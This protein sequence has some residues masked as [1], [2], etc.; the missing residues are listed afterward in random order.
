MSGS[1]IAAWAGVSG[2]ALCWAGA[3]LAQSAPAIEEIVVSA[4]KTEERLQDVPIAV[5]AFSRAT[6]DRKGVQDIS[7]LSGV[8]AGLS[9]ERDFGRR[10]DRPSIRGQ[11]SILGT[12]NAASFLDGVFIPDSL[13][14]TEMAFVERVEVIKGPQSA[15]Y[16]RQTFSGAISYVS[17]LPGEVPEGTFKATFAE[18]GEYDV[19][20]SYGGPIIAQKASLQVAAN[21]YRYGGEYKNNNPTDPYYGAKI[22]KEETRAGTAILR[23]TPIDPLT[24]TMRLSYAKN[25]D[26]HDATALQR[27]S[28]NNCFPNPA[29]GVPRYYCG[30]VIA[31]PADISLNLGLVDGGPLTRET[32]RGAGIIE[33]D[34]GPVKLTSVSGYTLSDE[35]RDADLDF[36][37]IAG[38]GG[39]LHVQDGIRIE[40]FSQEVRLASSP[41]ERLSWLVGGYYYHEDRRTD[42]YIFTTKRR[43]DNGINTTRNYA[44]FGLLRYDI[45]DRFSAS[46]ELR[47]ARDE[48]GLIGGD[49]HYNLSTAYNSLNPRFTLDYKLAND[50][51]VYGTVARG[52]KPGGFNSDVRL[53]G[54]QVAYDEE[55]SWNYEIGLKS[56]WLD[57][58][59]RVNAAAFFI[60]WNNQQLTQNA[61]FGTG[62]ISYIANVGALEVKGVELEVQAVPTNW[63]RITATG[64]ATEPKYTKG[65]DPEVGTLTGNPSIVGKIAPNTPQY[66]FYLASDF[67][68][69]V[70]DGVNGFLSASYQWRSEKYDQVGNFASTGDRDVVELRLGAERGGSRATL[71]VRN[72]LDNRD[73]L[74]VIRYVDFGVTGSPRGYQVGFP[75]GRQ[76]G[77]T[78]ETKF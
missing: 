15:L 53:T 36:L 28:K 47:W 9:Y 69:P 54:S 19:L 35:D 6:L 18:D 12:P 49:N 25:D 7:Q 72:L 57:R 61:I 78:L 77:V 73:P 16:G 21:Y 65:T 60:D 27:A 71:F 74:G 58:R 38:A 29:T 39:T 2:L 59:L 55:T 23:L 41:G 51:M 43:Q 62:S 67:D 56:E 76:V 24:V 63:W 40:A 37:P 31:T 10:L 50:V 48:L 26:G 64:S 70:T 68:F 34:F 14:S 1:K 8:V 42:R 30:V 46:A 22:G 20:A 3:A 17:K 11:S 13:F 52:N 4:R 45:T 32:T 44:G 33:Y 66:Q 75:R 5:S